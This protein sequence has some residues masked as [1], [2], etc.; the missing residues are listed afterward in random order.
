MPEEDFA[1]HP[2]TPDG[3]TW[4]WIIAANTFEHYQEHREEMEAWQQENQG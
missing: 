4:S 1:V 2:E 3:P